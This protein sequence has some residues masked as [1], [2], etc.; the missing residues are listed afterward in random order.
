MNEKDIKSLQREIEQLEQI[1]ETKKK[2]LKH[3]IENNIN[4]NRL[5][6]FGVFNHIE[7]AHN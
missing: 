3:E 7:E 1:L 6:H 5:N 2:R 4:L